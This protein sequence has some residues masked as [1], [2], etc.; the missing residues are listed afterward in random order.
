MIFT[1]T[2]IIGSYIIDIEP[3]GD[4]RGAFSRIFCTQEF[5][6]AGIDFAVAQISIATSHHAFTLRGMHFNAS[7]H[8]EAKLVRCIRGSVHEVMID[9]RRDSASYR[10]WF[11]LEMSQ[12]NGRALFVPRGCAQGYLT[13]QDDCDVLYQ[14]DRAYLPGVDRGVRWDDPAFGVVWPHQP[15]ILH[16]RDANYADYKG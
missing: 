4:E 14:M 11:G 8:E 2:P 7:P 13:L 15:Q 1:P 5:A 12:S 6:A 3:R 10:Q 9:L 16:P